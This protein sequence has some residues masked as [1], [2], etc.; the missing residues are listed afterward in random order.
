MSLR[1]VMS[2][3]SIEIWRSNLGGAAARQGAA[4]LLLQAGTANF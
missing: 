2:G 3:R 1:P 4:N